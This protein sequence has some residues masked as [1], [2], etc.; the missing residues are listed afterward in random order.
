[1]R[2]LLLISLS[3]L[4][5]LM[6][7][8]INAQTVK[9]IGIS[10]PTTQNNPL[11]PVYVFTC[12]DTACSSMTQIDYVT[13]I[14]LQGAVVPPVPAPITFYQTNGQQA[15]FALY[16]GTTGNWRSCKFTVDANG[17]LVNADTNCIGAVKTNNS[18]DTVT[19]ISFSA[20]GFTSSTLTPPPSAN[21][22]VTVP[23]RT[24]TFINDT[25]YQAVCLNTQAKYNN[26]AVNK[27]TDT[28][29]GDNILKH[30][31]ANKLVVTVPPLG[32][33]SGAAAVTGYQTADGTWVNT[34][35]YVNTQDPSNAPIYASKM[36]WTI[37][38]TQPTTS[39][40]NTT[41]GDT[42]TNHTIGMTNIDVSAVDGY[43]IGVEL[44]SSQGVVCSTASY[45][46]QGNVLPAEFNFYTG[47]LSKIP[48][49]GFTLAGLCPA[50]AENNFPYSIT[51]PDTGTFV[52]CLSECS[53]QKIL[54]GV[55]SDAAQQACCA[56][57]YATSTQCTQST[58]S[59]GQS[60]A[61]LP[62]VM[63]LEN[64]AERVYSWAYDDVQGDFSC[65]PAASYTF[66]LEGGALPPP[67][68]APVLA[69]ATVVPNNP[70]IIYVHYSSAASGGSG[71][72]ANYSY[73]ATVPNFNVTAVSFDANQHRFVVQVSRPIV[74]GHST[75]SITVNDDKAKKTATSN[76][77]PIQ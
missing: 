48:K 1:M 54:H 5:M 32:L 4:L 25:N 59:R 11:E 14:P 62:Y 64:G 12:S 44:T 74:P 42:I 73:S 27:C 76:V 3:T 26:P 61:Q 67:L 68:V 8:N 60:H 72:P 18:T 52:G 19:M 24:L 40:T 56:G 47:T 22:T 13:L 35:Q 2:R 63:N 39:M 71:N 75:V 16:Q 23:D 65:D 70:G 77:V 15:T 53:Y 69:A 34:G 66:T 55:D 29:N 20:A 36:E 9:H 31:D 38:P 33:I 49:T 21:Q 7:T 46:A 28:T 30:G 41:V 51:D 37:F 45:D 50:P 43:N 10:W 17:D 58:N 6:S 57:N